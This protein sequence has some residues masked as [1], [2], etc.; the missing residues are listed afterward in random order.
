[1][2]EKDILKVQHFDHI[3]IGYIEN[4][5]AERSE[6]KDFESFKEERVQ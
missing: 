2:I 4:T 5:Q 3:L 1:M 6:F